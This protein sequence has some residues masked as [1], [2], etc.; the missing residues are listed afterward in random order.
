M[1]LEQVASNSQDI[2]QKIRTG[3]L[4]FW[5]TLASELITMT[6]FRSERIYSKVQILVLSRLSFEWSKSVIEAVFSMYAERIFAK[7]GQTITEKSVQII[8]GDLNALFAKTASSL[9]GRFIRV[10]VSSLAPEIEKHIGQMGDMYVIQ[11]VIGASAI[12]PRFVSEMQ[13]IDQLV[14]KAFDDNHSKKLGGIKV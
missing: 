11:P 10:I 4:D 8:V 7:K 1:C 3:L 5:K 14:G 12:W 13:L 9:L 2:V 6:N